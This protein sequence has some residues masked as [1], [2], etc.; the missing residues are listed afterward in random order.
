MNNST[1][2]IYCLL[3]K[4]LFPILKF[5]NIYTDENGILR[6]VGRDPTLSY[7]EDKRELVVVNNHARYLEIKSKKDD[8]QIFNPFSIPKQCVFLA[9]MV[10]MAAN[11]KDDS[12]E[13]NNGLVYDED[14]DAYIPKSE[15][16]ANEDLSN[17][18]SIKMFES[19]DKD[20]ILNSKIVFARTDKSGN[21]KEELASFS[22]CNILMATLGGI[23]NLIKC[24][25][26][27][28]TPNFVA[29][30][31]AIMDIER[32]LNRIQIIREKEKKEKVS[33]LDINHIEDE[34]Q[35]CEDIN[36]VDQNGY[37]ID[38]YMSNDRLFF[39]EDKKW[40]YDPDVSDSK[41]LRNMIL[42]DF[43]TVSGDE[44]IMQALT[45]MSDL[46]QYLDVD[47]EC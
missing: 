4:Y 24:F 10:M 11:E 7:Q 41:I 6:P 35:M 18:G 17:M 26:R 25:Q 1:E 39:T 9:N 20:F 19:R 40:Q 5:A 21:P 22:H 31:L 42:P 37:F 14:L 15:D 13:N 3:E 38:P 8:Y 29:T 43:K 32:E 23:I 44:G 12:N 45:D 36:D 27:T 46:N 30:E 34:E 47:F 33:K 2:K 16:D 28:I